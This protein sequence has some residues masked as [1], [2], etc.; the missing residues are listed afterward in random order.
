[1]AAIR[2]KRPDQFMINLSDGWRAAIKVRAAKN[3]RSMNSEILAA[4]EGAVMAAGSV[5]PN[6]RPAA[7]DENATL[8]GGAL[9]NHA[10]KGDQRDRA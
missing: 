4:L 3:H 2:K 8:Q 10:Y 6:S 7:E 9:C 1:M 5:S